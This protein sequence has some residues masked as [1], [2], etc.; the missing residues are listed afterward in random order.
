MLISDSLASKSIT[1]K[2]NLLQRKYRSSPSRFAATLHSL[3]NTNAS[4]ESPLLFC[5]YIPRLHSNALHRKAKRHLAAQKKFKEESGRAPDV[6]GEWD[7]DIERAF[8][9]I[10]QRGGRSAY[11][12]YFDCLMPAVVKLFNTIQQVQVAADEVADSGNK[13]QNTSALV[14]R[15]RKDHFKGLI[16]ILLPLNC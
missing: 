12:F 11:F 14:R 1:K 7:V 4:S 16:F 5:S 2:E 3:L 8:R 10:A 15:T 9:K 6:M 13:V